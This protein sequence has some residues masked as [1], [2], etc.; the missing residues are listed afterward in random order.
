M[1]ITAVVEGKDKLEGYE[2]VI[3]TPDGKEVEVT[4]SDDGKILED[5][6]EVK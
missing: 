4:V 1:M 2:V 6:G 5:S 3:Q